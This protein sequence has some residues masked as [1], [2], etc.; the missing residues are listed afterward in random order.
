[1]SVKSSCDRAAAGA[2]FAA[3]CACFA[4]GLPFLAGVLV[5]AACPF[6]VASTDEPPRMARVRRTG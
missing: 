1:M 6:A 5:V 4:A 3:G 2:L